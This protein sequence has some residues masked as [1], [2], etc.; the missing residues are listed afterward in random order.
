MCAWA[1]VGELPGWPIPSKFL[2]IE[3]VLEKFWNKACSE[4]ENNNE[5][6]L[7]V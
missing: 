5:E 7:R 6:N 2:V 1:G 3:K 4:A